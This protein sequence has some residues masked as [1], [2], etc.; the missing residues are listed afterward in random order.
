[1]RDYHLHMRMVDYAK[2]HLSRTCTSRCTRVNWR[3]DW[4]RRMACVFHIREAVELGHAERIGHGVDVMYEKDP[5][6]L[7][8]GD[9]R[10]ACRWS[11]SI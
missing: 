2:K 8:E 11:K 4:C 6:G 7:A 9:A 3:P 5:Q 1:M 10:P